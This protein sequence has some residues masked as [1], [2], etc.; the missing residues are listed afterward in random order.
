[1]LKFVDNIGEL[2]RVHLGEN[3]A[4]RK[5]EYHLQLLHYNC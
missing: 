1:M 5:L 4:S 3:R 2:L